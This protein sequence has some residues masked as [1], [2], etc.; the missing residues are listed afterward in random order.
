MTIR[1]KLELQKEIDAR[2][3]AR[4]MEYRERTAKERE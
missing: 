2:N 4:V 3:E 1:Q